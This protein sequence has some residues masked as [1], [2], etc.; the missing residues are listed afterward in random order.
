M[1]NANFFKWKT[2]TDN[3]QKGPLAEQVLVQTNKF[4]LIR[5]IAPGRTIDQNLPLVTDLQASGG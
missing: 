3:K 2:V 1:E 4:T 5:G